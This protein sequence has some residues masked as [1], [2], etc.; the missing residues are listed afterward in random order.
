MRNFDRRSFLGLAGVFMLSAG[1]PGRAGLTPRDSAEL[2]FPQGI[3]SA[4]PQPG[5]VIL[6]TRALPIT[7]E[8]VP[9]VVQVSET[10]D[11]AEIVA[12]AEILARAGHDHTVRAQVSGLRAATIYYYRFLGL[13][14]GRSATGRTMT[15][16]AADDPRPVN[17]A[18]A[19][20]QN[21][22]QGFFGAWS[23]MITEDLQASPEEQIQLVLHLGDFIYERYGFEDREN[24]RYVRK[25]PDYPDGAG[26]GDLYWANTLADYR[27]LYKT[28]LSDPHLQAARARWPF[29]CTWDDHEFSNNAAGGYSTYNGQPFAEP[30]RK[31]AANQAWFEYIPARVEYS[32]EALRIYRSLRLGK[33][34]ELLI[35]D[36]RSYRSPPPIPDE[37]VSEWQLSPIPSELIEIFDAGRTYNNGAPPLTIT[38]G[39]NSRPNTAR[40]RS[41]GSMLGAAQKQWFKNRL[42]TSDATWK[43]WGNSLPILSLRLDLSALP[44]EGLQDGA[45]GQDAWPG[46]PTEYRELMNF[47]AARGITNV[48]SLSGDHHSHGAGALATDT[49][50]PRPEF[51][52]VD[53]NVSS[54][55]STP[56]F[57]QVLHEGMTGNPDFLQLVARQKDGHWEEVWNMT[58]TQGTLAAMVYSKTGLEVLAGW[59]SPNRANPGTRYVDSNSNGYGLARFEQGECRVQ[60]VTIIPPLRESGEQGQ[61]ILRRANFRLPSWSKNQ[62]PELE[63]P[64]FSGAPAFP[65]R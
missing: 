60:L 43:V 31:A 55:S 54:I 7:A 27:H 33:Q 38:H 19:S 29:V 47:L 42:E 24:Q 9:L 37:L 62:Q 61:E 22:E 3:A 34:L 16:A 23:R 56:Q 2:S 45:L 63:G 30:E 58:L 11:F 28:Y 32:P 48:V 20:C 36:L 21:Y 13:H 25:L 10:E 65:F 64:V 8:S 51:A 41:P 26:D 18:F 5:S 46:Y 17:L 44:R 53:F 59:L 57:A 49:N 14:G 1:A 52:A 50:A 6:W 12:E 40:G 35:T 15:A 4:D 39:G